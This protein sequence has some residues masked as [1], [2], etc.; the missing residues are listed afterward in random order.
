MKAVPERI[1]KYTISS[2]LGQGAMGV[3]YKGFDPHIQRTVAIK[4]VHKELRGEGGSERDS[5]AARF[6]NE[7]QAVGRIAHPGVVAIYD[8]GEDEEQAYIAME[9]VEG[10]SLDQVLAGTPL[11]PEAQILQIMDQLLDALAAA[12]AQGVWHRDIKPA[13]LLVTA[14]GQVKLTDFG[15]AR[16]QDVELTRVAAMIG[17]PGY[18][19]PEQY[20][21]EGINQRADIFAAGVLLYRM[22][23][24]RPAFSG[25]AEVVMYKILNEQ[26]VPPSVQ[27]QG[28]RPASYDAVVAKAMAKKADD[29]FASARDFRQALM[30]AVHAAQHAAAGGDA[31]VIVPPA[32]WAR[33]VEAAALPASQ[34]GSSASQGSGMT[35]S[36]PPTGW[37]LQ[38]LSRIERSL[39][40]YVG[41]MAKLMVRDA[42]K[43]C[44]DVAS[45]ANDV[46]VNITEEKQR[47]AFISSA[48]GGTQLAARSGATALTQ[49]APGATA[50]PPSPPTQ[51]MND[52]LTDE[53]KAQALQVLTRHLG[54]IARIVIKRAA[55]RAH[56]RA[57]FIE[58]ILDAAS[59][60]DRTTLERELKG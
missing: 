45:L 8:F 12:H 41:P 18:M 60:V 42:A 40:G 15:I 37:D 54:P 25:S 3:V 1:G 20:M 48:T 17:T 50:P 59:E 13:N 44:S 35:Q 16:I 52:P 24:G 5:I 4:T 22:L 47:L 14:N 10:R 26:P 57:Q 30:G 43:R 9:F 2:I 11:L 34:P 58:Q 33:A 23:T 7:A 49:R 28:A 55:E 31:T 56:G 21:G 6:R 36:A 38:T 32:Q 19:A 53:Y 51:L 39:A 27:S 29:R 46:S